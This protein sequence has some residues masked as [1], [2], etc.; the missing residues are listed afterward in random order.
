MGEA[1]KQ[2][3]AIALKELAFY[4]IS[5]FQTMTTPKISLL[6]KMELEGLMEILYADG[7]MTFRARPQ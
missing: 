7:E 6:L 1:Q 5:K 3:K 2:K 4:Q